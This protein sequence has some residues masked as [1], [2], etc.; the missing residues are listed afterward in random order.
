M[1]AH[2]PFRSFI[3]AF[4]A[5]LLIYAGAVAQ[6]PDRLIR[7][8][9]LS[10]TEGQVDYQRAQDSRDEWYEATANLPLDEGDQLFTGEDGRAEL[11]LTGGNVIRIN[12]RSN[13]QVSEFNTTH[14]QF[15]LSVGAATIRIESLDP[16][17]L[18]IVSLDAVGDNQPIYFEI[19][20]PVAAVTLLREGEYRI[21]VSE[22]GATEVIV[23]D[24]AAE[25]YNTEFGVVR[26][27]EGR[28]MIIEGEDRSEYRI[29]KL[30]DK[31]WWDQW[32][33]RRDAELYARRDA[34]ST[35]HVPGFV[36]GNYDLDHYG[37]WFETSDYGWAWS[38]RGVGSDWAP[39][40]HGCW[41][42]YPSFGW[43]WVAH[44]PWGWAPYHYGR[45]AFYSNRW[46]WVP[47]G[48]WTLGPGWAPGWNWSPSLVAFYGRGWRDGY[49]GGYRDG[50]RDERNDWIGWAPLGPRDI[51]S[52][53]GTVIAGRPGEELQNLRAPGG[54]SW[55]EGSRFTRSRVI[56]HNA[57]QAPVPTGTVRAADLTPIEIGRVRPSERGETPRIAPQRIVRGGSSSADAGLVERRA[58]RERNAV[59]DTRERNAVG[60]AGS[61][62]APSRVIASPRTGDAGAGDGRATERRVERG[63]DTEQRPGRVPEMRSI[64]RPATPARR[65]ARSESRPSYTPPAAAPSRPP[66]VT[67]PSRPVETER[68]PERIE[69]PRREETRPA[70]PPR[71]IE[72]Q[73][74]R[75]I[76]RQPERQPERRPESAPERRP[77]RIETPRRETPR[78]EAP[79]RQIERPA[80][81]TPERRGRPEG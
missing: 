76:E 55:V 70:P 6:N 38:P 31:D 22:D 48:A 27:K 52:P 49:R 81:P 60:D 2:A 45:W 74:E 12:R 36:A 42:W 5:L 50:R 59:Q 26:V 11:Q 40:R 44:E 29:A 68:R 13:L 77:E 43:T 35:R 28:R 17:R 8:V 1:K 53:T 80:Q 67:A 79:P 62:G 23:R 34:L 3:R 65:D 18:Q 24:G 21:N 51:P 56:V 10:L 20:T 30:R 4:S 61:A 58:T 7:V 75:R 66:A 69:T 9:R 72:R 57:P 39:Y 37:D 41:R 46:V 19:A 71:Q 25:V 54:M 73:P 63:F 15:A 78:P 33:D 47:R 16:R 32:N 14:M 64:E